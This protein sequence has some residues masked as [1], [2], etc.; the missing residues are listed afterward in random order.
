[1]AHILFTLAEES[2]GPGIWHNRHHT[3][4]KASGMGGRRK[5]QVETTM[6]PFS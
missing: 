5:G 3:R 4:G 1:M 6:P 2:A